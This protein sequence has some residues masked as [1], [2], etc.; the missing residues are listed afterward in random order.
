MGTMIKYHKSYTTKFVD[1]WCI[2]VEV[3][4]LSNDEINEDYCLFN[5]AKLRRGEYTITK[6]LREWLEFEIIQARLS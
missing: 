2:G 5:I 1:D 3:V 6:Y 4:D